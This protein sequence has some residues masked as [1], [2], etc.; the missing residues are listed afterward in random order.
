M[1]KF[2]YFRNLFVVI[3]FQSVLSPLLASETVF[4]CEKINLLNPKGNIENIQKRF[5]LKISQEKN[6]FGD[7]K[8]LVLYGN[9]QYQIDISVRIDSYIGVGTHVKKGLHVSS[10]IIDRIDG[11]AWLALADD[12]KSYSF[13]IYAKCKARAL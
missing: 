9:S 5:N 1:K 4:I 13:I 8:S 2:L 12:Y 7:F 6:V 3:F 11:G 10:L